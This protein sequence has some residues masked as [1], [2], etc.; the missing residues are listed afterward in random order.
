[1]SWWLEK[2]MRLIQTNLR[3][4][5][6]DLDPDEFVRNLEDFSADVVL[7]NAGGIVANY[8]TQLEYHYRNPHMRNDFM[9]E[10]MARTRK[11]GIRFMARFD[12][13]K[14]NQEMAARR[15]EWLY[16]S[17]EGERVNYNGQVHT[18]PNGGYQQDYSKQI[19]GEVIDRYAIDAV[20]FNMIGYVRRDY[21]GV[22]HGICQCENCR[23][24]FRERTGL[25]LP[26]RE[27]ADDPACL[28]LER[29][30]LETREEL[31]DDIS[32]F[33]KAKNPEIALC[34]YTSRGIDIWRKESNSG[35]G[36]TPPEWN[37]SASENTKSVLPVFEDKQV[38]NAAVHFVAMRFRHAAVPPGLTAL[39]M[40]ENIA[41]AAWLDYYVIGPLE[42]QDDRACFE[43]VRDLYRFYRDH[44]GSYTGLHSLA[45]VCLIHSPANTVLGREQEFRGMIRLLAESH[46]LYDIQP[47]PFL[48]TE[49]AMSRLSRYRVVIIPDARMLQP[50]VRTA[51]DR[52][53]SEG[54]TVIA[55]GLTGTHELDGVFQHRS[56]LQAS[57]IT[58]ILEVLEPAHSR[59]FRIRPSDK[60]ELSGFEQLDITFLHSDCMVCTVPESGRGLLGYIPPHMYGPPEKCYYDTETDIPGII[61]NRHGAGTFISLTWGIGQDYQNYGNHCHLRLL[62]S[63]LTDLAGLKPLIATDAS[64]LVEMNAQVRRDGAWLLI[65]LVNH[66]GQ[67]GMAFHRPI[68]MRAIEFQ[69]HTDRTIRTVEAL[70]AGTSLDFKQED[71][72]VRIV[73]PELGLLETLKLTFA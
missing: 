34:T 3:E 14:L 51:L 40:A 41:N 6:A 27:V 18:C 53:V 73:L 43:D 7:F 20:F 50:G 44:E 19:L 38:S 16:L 52:Y 13:S 46:I 66:A 22:Y 39:R 64:P 11:A 54:G 55:T 21:S 25:E 8:D 45:D 56:L 62:Q 26:I 71:N 12:F 68:P 69:V 48:D 29:F 60:E 63:V 10:V 70:R 37:Y 28:A 30:C 36:R 23:S 32:R 31:F 49:A 72:L 35:L 4:I 42:R 9:R 59:Y 57:G 47:D 67:N 24:R 15:P 65:S 1:M 17:P 58:E 2:P 33:V 61:V 5:D